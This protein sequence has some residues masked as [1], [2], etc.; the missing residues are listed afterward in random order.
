[1]VVEI[2]SL[3]DPVL[4]RQ[5][6]SEELVV[7]GIACALDHAMKGDAL[8]NTYPSFFKNKI[9]QRTSSRRLSMCFFF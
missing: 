3:A 5:L 9:F 2:K 8:V 1:V 6:L 4:T 7:K